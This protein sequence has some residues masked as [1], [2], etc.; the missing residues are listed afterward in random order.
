MPARLHS[1]TAADHRLLCLLFFPV[2]NK[3]SWAL[4]YTCLPTGHVLGVWWPGFVSW[5]HKSEMTRTSIR[6]WRACASPHLEFDLKIVTRCDLL[7]VPTCGWGRWNRH[8]AKIRAD[9]GKNCLAVHKPFFFLLG[10]RGTRESSLLHRYTWWDDWVLATGMKAC[11]VRTTSALTHNIL[12]VTLHI[13]SYAR[14]LLHGKNLGPFCDHLKNWPL[15]KN[16]GI[17]T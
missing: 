7:C 5:F 12:Y 17:D 6:T 3:T 4:S 1:L 11:V 16:T 14:K 15:I 9:C 13:L 8:L 10:A 2:L